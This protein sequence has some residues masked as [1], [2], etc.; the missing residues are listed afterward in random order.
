M[1]HIEFSQ[2]DGIASVTLN[3]PDKLNALSED[4]K[5]ELGDIFLRLA[6][7]DAARVVLLSAQGRGFC[8]SGDVSTMGRF[9]P[10][11]AIERL[12][13]A[14]R[15]VA[16]LANLEKPVIAAVRGPVAGIGWSLALACDVILASE[17]AVFSQ[18]FK[19]VGL[20]PDGGAVFFLAQHLGPIRAKELI[21]SARKVPAGEAEQLGLV[22]KVVPDGELEEAAAAWAK[23][24][25]S[26]PGFSYAVTKKMFKLM[27]TP[28]LEAALDTEAWAQGLSLLTEDHR[29]G[30][31]AFLEKRRPQFKGS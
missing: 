30:A 2:R 4:M 9:T 3:R 8:A 19:N 20:I 14:H 24:L 13:R 1:A 16:A 12:K 29:E 18:V 31:T 10:K 28:S 7:D 26:G 23:E 17:T 27:Y 5:Q 22:T 21:L 25:A 11:S 15:V 6:S